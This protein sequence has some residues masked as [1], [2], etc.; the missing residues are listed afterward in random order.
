VLLKSAL[1]EDYLY[2]ILRKEN[3]THRVISGYNAV[4]K[5]KAK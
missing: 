3:I 2:V 5:T 1:N 4:K